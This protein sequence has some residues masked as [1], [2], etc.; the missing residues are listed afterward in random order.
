MNN[1]DDFYRTF[2]PVVPEAPLMPALSDRE[3]VAFLCRALHREGYDDH[4]AG[5]ITVAAGNGEYYVNPWEVRWDEI[6][7][8]DVIKMD[9]EGRVIEGRWNVTPAVRV[10]I[11]LHK[12]R[13][14]V[15][16][17]IHNH[18]RWG[19]IWANAKRIPPIYDQT[20]AQTDGDPILVDEYGQT[21]DHQDAA[22]AGAEAIGDAKCALLAHHGVLVT[23]SSIPQA[24]LRAVTLE[25]RC[26]NAYHTEQ[27]GGG[28]PMPAAAASEIGARLDNSPCGF[29][30]LWESAVRRELRDDPAIQR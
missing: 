2:A 5:H 14:D 10:H 20:S 21:F 18:S 3:A 16:V 9:S 24:Y 30:F 4:L 19:T 25:W 29:P 6:R 28:Q 27:I 8:S 12:L 26:R 11:E 22:R 15:K 23:G 13:S 1:F 7:A 17:I